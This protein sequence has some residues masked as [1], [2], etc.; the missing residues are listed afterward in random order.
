MFHRTHADNGVVY[1]RSSLLD[2][3]SV[4]HAF[5]TRMGGVSPEPFASLNLG[6]PGKGT[7]KDPQANLDENYRRLLHA[8]S[9]DHRRRCWVN[10]VHANAVVLARP[11]EP[12]NNGQAAD[13][14]ICT[15]PALVA[16]IRVADCVPILL[17][18]E[19]G[20]TVAAIHAGWRGIIAGIVPGAIGRM[21]ALCPRLTPANLLA[22]VGPCI[23]RD[24]FEVGPEVIEEFRALFGGQAEEFINMNG[25]KGHIDL[26]RAVRTQLQACALPDDH[27]DLA[28]LCTYDNA[29]DFYSHR[30]DAGLTGRMAAVIG[31]RG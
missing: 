15:D 19:D 22:A 31:C 18:T 23:G 8:I 16:A 3:A 12:F 6:N 7:P 20:K 24:A 21:L 2:A 4:P 13:G 25:T 27:I 1:Y 10:Q 5:S 26:P 29:A 28:N 9:C 17:A 30:R 14:I 11:A